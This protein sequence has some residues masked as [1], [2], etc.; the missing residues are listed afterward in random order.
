MVECGGAAPVAEQPGETA[1]AEPRRL[2]AGLPDPALAPQGHGADDRGMM[3]SFYNLKTTEEG[4]ARALFCRLGL[5]SD[6]AKN[7]Y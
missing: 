1:A 2:P 6:C 5:I 7:R 4:A 3:A